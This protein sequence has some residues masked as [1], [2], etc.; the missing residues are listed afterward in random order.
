MN[1][2]YKLLAYVYVKI[3]NY[4]FDVF[5]YSFKKHSV[6][7][8]SDSRG[9]E[10]T[11]YYKKRN[12]IF[13]YVDFLDCKYKIDHR[14]CPHKYTSILDFLELIY[15]SERQ[16]DH[17]I[18]HCGI[19]DFAPRPMSSY[20]E[21]LETKK[22][23]LIEKGW[24]SYFLNRSDYLCD[25]YGEK[26]IQFFSDSFLNEI[27]I[28]ELLKID[29]IIY[30]GVNPV[31]K[32]W[33]GEYWRDRPDCIN[34]QIKSNEYMLSSIVNHVD[35]SQWNDEDIMAYTVDNVHYNKA[36]LEFIGKEIN[37]FLY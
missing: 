9:T 37:K 29:N 25:Y 26:T 10:V 13:S 22:E 23:F 21:M 32:G 28:P 4:F 35:I 19:V 17:I 15:S 11:S 8:Y 12:V 34:I 14:F 6:L 7:L 1:I 20:F 27:I 2:V 5:K 30:V 18:L 33:R 24:F 36:G 3:S 31:I 16:Y